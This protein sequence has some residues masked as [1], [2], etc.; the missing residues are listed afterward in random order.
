MKTPAERKSAE[1]VRKKEQGL[2]RIE[3][4]VTDAEAKQLHDF[5]KK[6]RS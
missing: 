6:L 1:R 2:K 3:M 5:L 4:W